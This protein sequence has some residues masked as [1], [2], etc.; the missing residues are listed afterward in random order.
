M[1]ERKRLV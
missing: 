1:G